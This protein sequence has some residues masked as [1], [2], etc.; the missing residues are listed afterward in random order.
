MNPTSVAINADVL[1]FWF[2]VRPIFDCFRAMPPRL[3]GDEDR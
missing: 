1:T 2:A 3:Y